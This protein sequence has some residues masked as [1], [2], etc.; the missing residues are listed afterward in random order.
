MSLVNDK[1]RLDNIISC[2]SGYDPEAMHIETATEIICNLAKSY[3]KSFNT[4]KVTLKNC[5]GR[6]L[7]NDIISTIDVPAQTNSAMDG[8]A[9]SSKEFSRTNNGCEERFELLVVGAVNAGNLFNGTVE[10]GECVKIMTGAKMPADLDTVIPIEFIQQDERKI[11][12]SR[13]AVSS[14]ANCRE[15][16]EDLKKGNVAVSKGRLLTPSDLGLI[17]SLGISSVDV[18]K[19]IKIGY[20]STGDELRSV[21]ESLVEGC[22]FDSNRYSILGMLKNLPVE[23]IDLGIVR[24]DIKELKDSFYSLAEKTD[25]IITSGGVSVGEAD[26]TKKVMKEV[27]NVKFWKI[28]MR[29]GRPMAVG[30]IFKKDINDKSPVI[31]F[32][33]PGNPVAVMVTFYSLVL[34]AIH[35]LAGNESFKIKTIKLPTITHIKK[36]KGRTEFRRGV[37]VHKGDNVFVEQQVNQGSGILSSMSKADCFLVLGHDDSEYEAGE[38]VPVM[39][40]NGLF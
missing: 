8:F 3:K 7:C 12:F 35:A 13:K 14:R 11:S 28:A 23:C 25:L 29:P 33:L 10:P 34:P 40:F 38:N 24:D 20:F 30:E 19:K 21:G 26:F 37:L 1:S 9:F 4:E 31:L 22:I 39:I 18:Y 17:A 5:L 32:G 15:L 6:V 36:K 2:L 16:G 27:G